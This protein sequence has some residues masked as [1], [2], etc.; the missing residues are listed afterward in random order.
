MAVSAL[1]IPA[2]KAVISTGA[3][4]SGEAPVFM[5][6]PKLTLA[7]LTILIA[8]LLFPIST[9]VWAHLPNLAYLQFPWRLLTILSAVLA[10]TIAL[11]L[12]APFLT[13]L[14]RG[15][16]GVLSLILVL[17]LP[18]ALSFTAYTLY[19]QACDHPSLPTS[20][21]ALFITH[22]GAPPTD[23]YTPSNADNDQ[24][25]TD[26][27]GYWL[28]SDPNSPAP[29][30][31]PTPSELNPNISTDDD[32]IPDSQTLST[33]TPHHFTIHPTKPGYLILNLREYPN[34]DV[35]I[36][37]ECSMERN[38]PPHINRDDGLIAVP[39]YC[40][41]QHDI[42]ISWHRTLDQTLGLFTSALA[43]IA[44]ILTCR[45]RQ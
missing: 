5:P 24:L 10:F 20:I 8:V 35:T 27:P 12:G 30:T 26:N 7:L 21:A 16:S 11:I 2:Y 25:R 32:P 9:P 15:M 34:W 31:T 29:D 1:L 13:R 17:L 22:H 18:V 23:E 44:L 33:P 38:H 4:R 3:Q 40:G 42:D 45:T 43:L 14:H 39:I 36:A 28:S 19:A 37:D 41:A 6:A